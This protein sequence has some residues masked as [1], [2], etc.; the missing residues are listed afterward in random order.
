MTKDELVEVA[1]RE[2]DMSSQRAQ[3]ETVVTL[4]ERIRQA[5]ARAAPE[6]EDEDPL[7]K[8]PKG[9]ERMSLSDLSEECAKRNISIPMTD[10]KGPTRANLIV[11]IRDDVEER[12]AVPKTKTS[13]SQRRASI[14]RGTPEAGGPMGSMPP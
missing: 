8:I 9:L 7:T 6:Q 13:G 5:R 10:K 11:L 3:K 4:R 2:L 12:A 14:K 1:R